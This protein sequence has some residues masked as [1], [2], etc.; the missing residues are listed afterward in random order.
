MHC[1]NV[2]QLHGVLTQGNLFMH[3]K[4]DTLAGLPL[5]YSTI[6]DFMPCRELPLKDHAVWDLQDLFHLTQKLQM[7]F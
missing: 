3:Y 2:V 7:L 6:K 1:H 4:F 5:M